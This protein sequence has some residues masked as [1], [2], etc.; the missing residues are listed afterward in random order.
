M[1]FSLKKGGYKME[2]VENIAKYILYLDKNNEI[3][4]NN[5]I[6]LNGRDCYEGN[7][8]YANGL[9]CYDR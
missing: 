4:I 1:L 6:N 5:L 2:K 3:F 9:F 8:N 7:V